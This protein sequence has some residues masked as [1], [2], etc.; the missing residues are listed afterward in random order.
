MPQFFNSFNKQ[1]LLE[2][3]IN[4]KMKILMIHI[5]EDFLVLLIMEISMKK[6][7]KNKVLDQ[8]LLLMKK[9]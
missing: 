9:D 1:K 4:L 7:Q 5:L 6:N 3:I 8:V 2:K